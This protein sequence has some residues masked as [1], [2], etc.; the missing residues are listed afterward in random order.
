MAP[1]P[2]PEVANRFRV[3]THG[4]APPSR[5]STTPAQSSRGS[6]GS[7]GYCPWINK[8][9][10]RLPSKSQNSHA[11]KTRRMTRNENLLSN[12]GHQ[13][14]AAHE[15]NPFCNHRQL[16]HIV[17][18]GATTI[19]HSTLSI[20]KDYCRLPPPAAGEGQNVYSIAI[21]QFAV[22]PLSQSQNSLC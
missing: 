19:H 2:A 9:G 12:D 11:P 10:G 5:C 6:P 1:L 7:E 14:Q 4:V 22:P 16:S 13:H 15:R 3:A 21:S 17:S 18:T 20:M 8:T